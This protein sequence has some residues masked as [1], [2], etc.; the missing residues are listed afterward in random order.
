[1]GFLWIKSSAASI[2]LEVRMRFAH[3]NPRNALPRSGAGWEPA[4]QVPTLRCGK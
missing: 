4:L 1:M 2:E 3:R